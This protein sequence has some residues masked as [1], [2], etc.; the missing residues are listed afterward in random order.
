MAWD[1]PGC[2]EGEL[3][4]GDPSRAA[5]AM[6]A[7]ERGRKTRSWCGSGSGGLSQSWPEESSTL[8]LIRGEVPQ[9]LVCIPNSASAGCWMC[10]GTSG[11]E[12]GGHH[13]H[14]RGH[15]GS[16]VSLVPW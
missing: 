6:W 2:G 14:R 16:R 5:V 3:G 8:G 12:L 1:M 11:C 13:G 7:A 4:R 15:A 10:W 9:A